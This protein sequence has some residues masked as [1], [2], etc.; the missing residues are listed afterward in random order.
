MNGSRAKKLR[1]LAKYNMREERAGLRKYNIGQHGDWFVRGPR[2][3]YKQ[4][5]KGYYGRRMASRI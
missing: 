4:L 2:A 3:L 5:K 1:F